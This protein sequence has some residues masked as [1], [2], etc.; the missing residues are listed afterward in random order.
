MGHLTG[1]TTN[2]AFLSGRSFTTSYSYDAG[3]N[4][5]GLTDPESGLTTYTYDTLNRLTTLT[6]FQNHPFT[7]S[8]DALSRRTQLTR[9][10]GVNTTYVYDA[11]S[12]LLSVTHQHAGTTLDGASYTVDAA[13]NRLSRTAL[14]GTTATNFT[15]DAIYELLT[16][17][18]GR[19]NTESY[20]YDP[21]GNRLSSLS[22]SSY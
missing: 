5:S 12:R 15:Y 19:K 20:T 4:R 7:F 6:D 1:A 14:P 18:Q 16:A 22:F 13:G 17:A 10:N 9:P 8:G 11:L 3:S 2:Y 21:V